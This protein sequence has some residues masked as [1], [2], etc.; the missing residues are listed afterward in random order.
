MGRGLDIRYLVAVSSLVWSLGG[1]E[2]LRLTPSEIEL[3]RSVFEVVFKRRLTP[4]REVRNLRYRAA[5]S[6]GSRRYRL[7]CICYEDTQGT[8]RVGAGLD[9]AEALAIIDQMLVVYP[10][11]KKDKVL[12]Y[13]D[14]N[15]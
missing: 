4:T 8:V 2:F 13:M 12:E 6:S 14:L 1:I 15:T 7:G 3:M 9:D 11:P 10:F 5:H